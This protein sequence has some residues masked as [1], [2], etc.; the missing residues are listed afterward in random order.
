MGTALI[1]SDLR[2]ADLSEADLTEADLANADLT[3]ANLSRTKLLLADLINA[4]LEGSNLKGAI[5]M[6][7]RRCHGRFG[8]RYDSLR[9]APDLSDANGSTSRW[10]SVVGNDGHLSSVR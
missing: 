1:N 2:N 6:H 7:R 9:R 4:K 8:S 3:N 10:R 5:L